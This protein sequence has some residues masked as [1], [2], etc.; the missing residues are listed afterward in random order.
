M[1]SCLASIT[2][3]R[4]RQT[5][6]DPSLLKATSPAEE[7]SGQNNEVQSRFDSH[8]YF[9]PSDSD[10]FMVGRITNK[11]DAGQSKSRQYAWFLKWIK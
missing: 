11:Q 1:Q 7:P 6:S 4:N 5:S 2:C 9:N 10:C 8:L 3:Y